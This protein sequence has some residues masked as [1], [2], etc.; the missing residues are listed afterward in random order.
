MSNVRV[1]QKE[2][3]PAWKIM[4]TPLN[5]ENYLIWTKYVSL[6]LCGHGKYSYV[7]RKISAPEESDSSYPEWEQNDKTVMA[8][9]LNS[10]SPNVAEGFLFMDMTKEIW[11]VVAEIYGE[12]ENIARIFKL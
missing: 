1:L 4:S 12:K 3:N 9:L 10:M 7:N 6:Y 2:P 5:G 11:D 8:W